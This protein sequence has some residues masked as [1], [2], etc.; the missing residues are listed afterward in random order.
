MRISFLYVVLILG[1]LLMLTQSACKKERFLS[2]GGDLRYSTDTLAFDTVFTAQGSFTA[3]FKIYN[4]QPQRIKISSVRLAGGN[5]SYFAL[6]VDGYKGKSVQNI[7][8]APNDS[9]FVFATVNV[10]PTNEN[11]P[12]VVE[13]QVI[14]TMNGNDYS[15]PLVAYGQN[16]YYIYDSV[17]TTQTWLTDKP[18]VII[19][20]AA[21]DRNET[22]TIPAGCRIYMHA[23]SNLYVLG[24][25][26]VNGTKSDSVVFQGDRLDR[27][28]FGYEGYPGEWGGIFFL[29]SSDNSVLDYA[30]LKNCGNASAG[31]PAALYATTDTSGT[32][33]VELKHV[34]V[35]NS[36]GY[37]LICFTA[38]VKAENCLFH[39]CGAQALAIFQGGQ[40]NFTNCD[41]VNFGT[42]KVSHIDNP[43]VAVLNYFKKSETEYI[44]GDLSNSSFVNC[45]IWG[46][47]SNEL[48]LDKLDGAAYQLAFEHCI[49]RK[50]TSED[51]MPGYI[52][53][54]NNLVNNDPL[55][56][57][58]SKFDF[59]LN[60]GSPA[61]NNGKLVNI[62]NDLDD[63]IWDIPFDIGCYQY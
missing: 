53:E 32:A 60:A 1:G 7:E 51:P 6:N 14:A 45:I 61:I 59:H 44:V 58:P 63:K 11:T 33:D 4:P 3:S 47:L 18:Y 37:G 29:G 15:L 43:T 13:D 2:S 38:V 34:I 22:L 41:F 19:N 56:K 17:L 57:D 9:V 42:N 20:S 52:S 39:T 25:L 24:T 46:S 54:L 48:V 35:E 10:D 31:L 30:V 27:A 55:F 8:I 50:N 12:F 16:A 21:V 5:S 62:G 26:K 23:N 36:I 28:Y 40:Y 49:I